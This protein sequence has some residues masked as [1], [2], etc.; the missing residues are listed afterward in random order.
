MSASKCIIHVFGS[1]VWVGYVIFQHL[2]SKIYIN[3][4]VKSQL[5]FHIQCSSKDFEREVPSSSV[6]LPG[7]PSFSFPAFL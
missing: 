5:T 7:V 3:T 4:F 6:A 2:K 1:G